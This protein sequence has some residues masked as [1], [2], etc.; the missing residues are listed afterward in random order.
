M[1]R[2]AADII[3]KYKDRPE[4]QG[5][6]NLEAYHRWVKRRL[7]FEGFKPLKALTDEAGNCVICGEAGRCPGYHTEEE[8]SSEARWPE[9]AEAARLI[10]DRACVAIN[11]AANNTKSK[12]R[13]K[14]QGILEMVI[15]SLE[16]RV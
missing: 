13:Y 15:K 4:Y 7:E 8:F 11:E 3:Q 9:L 10:A 12:A 1:T 6:E 16:A 2:R 14:A 5:F